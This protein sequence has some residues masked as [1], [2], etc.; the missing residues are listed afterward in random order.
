MSS[1]LAIIVVK[2]G[3]CGRLGHW[4]VL[5]NDDVLLSQIRLVI[6][7]TVDW[8]ISIC[9]STRGLLHLVVVYY[10]RICLITCLAPSVI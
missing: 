7:G 4:G 10:A 9:A 2:H 5:L 6:Q 8:L 1:L 3:R